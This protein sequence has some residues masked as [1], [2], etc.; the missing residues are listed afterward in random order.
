MIRDIDDGAFIAIDEVQLVP[1]ADA[2]ILPASVALFEAEFDRS[3]QDLIL[4]QDGSAV[5]T[6]PGYFLSAAPV[7]LVAANG[8]VLSGALATRLAG[9]SLDAQYAQLS[10]ADGPLPIGQ[11]EISSGLSTVQHIDGSVE[12]L[13][14][15]VKIYQNDILST[16]SDGKVSITFSDGTIFSL[17]QSSRMVIDTL[18]YDPEGGENAG[19]FS[20]LTGGF[21]FIAGQVAKTGDMDVITPTAT[22]GIRG[23][24]VQAQIEVV[25]GIAT[26]N[27]ALNRDPDG[28][29]GSIELIDLEGN[30][31][32]MITST[33]TQWIVS[34]IE[35]QTREVERTEADF[36]SDSVLLADALAAFQSAVRRVEA[37]ETFVELGDG[38][39]ADPEGN[40]PSEN[41]D[42]LPPPDVDGDGEDAGGPETGPAAEPPAG[43]NTPAAP[44]AP[45]NDAGGEDETNLNID[46]NR[47]GPRPTAENIQVAGA[48]DTPTDNPITGTA[49]A[50]SEVEGPLAFQL[51]VGPANGTAQMAQDGTFTYVPKPD[52]FGT[53]S[54]TYQVTDAD[55]KTDVGR[56]T[57]T[58][59]DVNDAPTFDNGT[60]FS[61]RGGAPV[62]LT[63]STLVNDSDAGDIQ[64]FSLPAFDGPGSFSLSGNVL[65]FDP[66]QDFTS[67][68]EDETATVS[69][70]ATVQDKGGELATST[71]TVTVAGENDAP[72]IIDAATNA[73]ED[74]AAVTLDLST[75]VMDADANDT[76]SFSLSPYS[77]PGTF[78]VN[79]GVLSFDPGADFQSLGADET[80][81]VSVNVTVT[82]KG[83]E[84]A[85]SAVAVTVTGENDAPILGPGEA[86]RQYNVNEDTAISGSIQAADP[87][88]D[89]ITYSVLDGPA[90]GSAVMREN[91]TFSY[92]P[93]ANYEGTDSFT[94][95]ATDGNGSESIGSVTLT[96]APVNDAPELDFDASVLEGS[97][98]TETPEQT[99]NTAPLFR[100]GPSLLAAIAEND[101]AAAGNIV[102]FDPDSG[103]SFSASFVNGSAVDYLGD[104]VLGAVSASD[105]AGEYDLGWSFAMDQHIYDALPLDDTYVQTYDVT[106]LDAQGTAVSVTITIDITGLNDAPV[107]NDG[108]MQTVEDGGVVSL[109]L[110]PLVVDADSGDTQTFA[111][112]AYAGPGVFSL[113]DDV[114]TFDPGTD[115]QTLGAN[116]TQIVAANLR[117]TDA[118]GLEAVSLVNVTVTGV[119]D[120][121]QIVDGLIEMA[122]GD[123]GTLD[124]ATLVTDIDAGDAQ[125]F[126]L[127][128]QVGL[129]TFSLAG[130]ILHFDPGPDFQALN[131]SQSETVS[132]AVTVTDAAGEEASAT[133]VVIVSGVNNAPVFADATLQA[134]EDGA[135]VS[136]NVAPLVTDA[137]AGDTRTFNL[138][139]SAGQG[140]FNLQNEVLSFD[141]GADF[142]SLQEGETT[143][144]S[145][146]VSVADAI[147]ETAISTITVTVT[148][149]NDAP[150]LADA[151]MT[152]TEDGNAVSL[153]LAGL[154]SDAD[155]GDTASFSLSNTVGTGAFTLSGDTLTFDPGAD[156]QNLQKGETTTVSTHVTVQDSAGETAT[157]NVTVTITGTNEAPTIGDGAMAATEDGGHVSLGLGALVS[158]AD[159]A[160]TVPVFS[161]GAHAEQGTFSLSGDVLTFDPGADFQNLAQGETKTTAVEVTV[162]DAGGETASST[163]TVTVTGEN[164]APLFVDGAMSVEEDGD[165]V[166]LNL[167][168][169]VTDQDNGDTLLFS[170]IE[171]AASGTFSLSGAVLSFDPGGDF[172][173]LA[174]GETTSVSAQ[175]MVQDNAGETA[176]STI[177]VTVMGQND[178]PALQDGTIDVAEDGGRSSVDLA[179]LVVDPDTGGEN[180]SFSLSEYTGAGSFVLADNILSFDPGADFQELG[181]GEVTTL[182]TQL[183]VQDSAGE[184]ASSNIT[185]S[186]TG[187]N[188]LPELADGAMTAV[189][190]GATTSL[191]L[192][193]LVRDLDIGDT[194]TF[195]LV[196][197]AGPG[198]FSLDG[199]ILS[200][201]PGADFQ[202]LGAD[203][204]TTVTA[205]ISVQDSAGQSATSMITVTV[206]G[207]NDEPVAQDD[208]VTVAE[209]SFALFN[210]RS[211]D[212][213]LDGDALI[214]LVPL[215]QGENGSVQRLGPNLR[216]IPDE[217]FNGQDSF[218][219]TII[220]GSGG[221]SS[222]MVFVTVTPVND[223]PVIGNLGQTLSVSEDDVLS[224]GRNLAATDVDGDALTYSILGG[225]NGTYGTASINAQGQ[226]TYTLNNEAAAVQDLDEGDTRTDTF[227]LQVSDGNG[228]TDETTGT[229][230]VAGADEAAAAPLNAISDVVIALGNYYAG[231]Y[232]GGS[233]VLDPISIDVLAND[234][235][236]GTLSVTD[237]GAY[238]YSGYSEKGEY[239]T[240]SG[241]FTDSFFGHLTLE[242]DQTL[243]ME[244][245]YDPATGF[246]G[247]DTFTYTATDDSLLTD[248]AEVTVVAIDRSALALGVVEGY[249][250]YSEG[251]YY[252][253][254]DSAYDDIFGEASVTTTLAF[255]IGKDAVF[256]AI[257]GGAS[258]IAGDYGTATITENGDWSY[259]LF[260]N[261]TAAQAALALSVD[262]AIAEEFTLRISDLTGGF[263]TT[264][265]TAFVLEDKS[266]AVTDFVS[267]EGISSYYYANLF[268]AG[269]I[270][271]DVLDNDTA[272]GDTLI[273][274]FSAG[275]YQESSPGAAFSIYDA[276]SGYYS[277]LLSLA[278]DA[279]SLTFTPYEGFLGL[280][281]FQYTFTDAAGFSDSAVVNVAVIEDQSAVLPPG[282]AEP[283]FA[284][285]LDTSGPSAAGRISVS[286]EPALAGTFSSLYA[287]LIVD[288]NY[289]GN[290]SVDGDPDFVNNDPNFEIPLVSLD[291]ISDELGE[292]NHFFLKGT[293]L[294]APATTVSV[295]GIAEISKYDT[296]QNNIGSAGN[297]VLLGSGFADTLS[298]GDGVDAILGFAGDDQISISGDAA[299]RLDGGTGRDILAFLSP[300]TPGDL[301]GL[302][303]VI[304]NIEALDF[305]ND[306]DD[307]IALTESDIFGISNNNDVDLDAILS[308]NGFGTDNGRTLMILGED[309]VGTGG[310]GD[311]IDYYLGLSRTLTQIGTAVPEGGGGS[312]TF[313]IWQ[314][315]TGGGSVL[316]TLGIDDDVTVNVITSA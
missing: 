268:P 233:Y 269:E 50:T 186:V 200:F 303:S 109:S 151:T 77:G 234:E 55:G 119:N 128:A 202:D 212:V 272:Y 29:V 197:N 208:F 264:T 176:T 298:G 241:Y 221:S 286:A 45:T 31:I 258:S 105:E 153:S 257:M 178:A 91:G 9:A 97:I 53:D 270:E 306:G 132:V 7:D 138:F 228:G 122:D 299:A 199:N 274:S 246:F 188:D 201:D 243:T 296:A 134:A 10:G 281:S 187:V 224:A 52:F 214:V 244:S 67:L 307:D 17:A 294:F 98:P 6:V 33:D 42:P 292:V 104:F 166:M 226:W 24:T 38:S 311:E 225:G 283:T 79:A 23:T 103:D 113:Q 285:E 218:T 94:Y 14:V 137:D 141:P 88:G 167:A 271:I 121:P 300:N 163:I 206:T 75:L 310:V 71:I 164:D 144:V 101:P 245:P 304:S 149:E 242:V 240:I 3:G 112:D 280:T 183:T 229:V 76:Q 253:Y 260:E 193:T 123:L 210:V 18:I 72:T 312:R 83:G 174:E 217:N 191:A 136:L 64:L 251:G 273:T 184:T 185:I 198:S 289:I 165:A 48:E 267:T 181:A 85:T 145:A 127:G 215:D 180:P 194:Q 182:T 232:Y 190:D 95:M 100:A 58:V 102:L 168:G 309:S 162:Q 293:Y 2:L 204:T 111:L 156:F 49:T 62:S 126:I 8:A 139:S 57:V 276:D 275:A 227:T 1:G 219:Y 13:D 263:A 172:Q 32:T 120:A 65:T 213:D 287:D 313:D 189:E 44:P 108:A 301:S 46:N 146:Q 106:I 61:A 25:G 87:D 236:T 131:S 81:T 130:N 27:V 169:M 11:V 238:Y 179:T 173:S 142:Q 84:T 250:S 262:G 291:G 175:V 205:Q 203:E 284:I 117:V 223:A 125:N 239:Y 277:G 157:S 30:L 26:L 252:Q 314:L 305:E 154:V 192:S 290:Y 68:G 86:N 40:I 21:V 39:G 170:I 308:A 124:L 15:G 99:E 89:P 5:L 140:M 92:V 315:E 196:E 63:L 35:G 47:G 211:N 152:A 148:G 282:A 110:A 302:F 133:A 36:A 235:G 247:I 249:F 220:D 266:D 177:V 135:V 19:G 70:D 118:A 159:G 73:A 254:Y 279:K 93:D 56:V 69:I 160:G 116:E 59:E 4:S 230:I 222:A 297:D 207:Q 12:E 288:G 82:D 209:G 74:G 256:G 60:L 107:F 216:Y 34:P 28:S 54:F 80:T 150:T 255:E 143:N 278:L 161:L 22:M 195:S 265:L 37:G 237:Y 248:D 171:G 20:L 155:A 78:G 158:D 16:T 316:A 147:G 115:F 259:A 295:A 231:G 129:G 51:Q 261:A 41:N 114:L 43:G 90:H 96:F 66:G